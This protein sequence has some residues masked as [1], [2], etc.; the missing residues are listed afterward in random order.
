[1]AITDEQ[2]NAFK[3][4]EP[5]TNADLACE[6]L[7]E[8]VARCEHGLQYAKE[9]NMGFGCNIRKCKR[10]MAESIFLQQHPDVRR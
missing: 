6:V 7:N 3:W 2:Y 10:Q 4:D 8:Y 5:I 1:M 9:H